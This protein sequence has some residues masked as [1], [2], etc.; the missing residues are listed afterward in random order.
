MYLFFDTETT[1]LPRDWS[2]PVTDLTN[3]PRLV[4]LAW[5]FYENEGRLVSSGNYIIRPNGFRIPKAASSIHGITTEKAHSHGIAL[6]TALLEF[7]EFMKASRY[8][9]A[10][11]ISFD[12]KIVAAEL[13]RTGMENLFE[14]KK[15][16]C[17]MMGTT[18]YCGIEGNYGE[19]WP[20]L[21]ELHDKVFKETF[22]D[23]HDAAMDIKITAK[24]FWELRKRRVLFY[25]I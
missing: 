1:G 21:T 9:I 16:I 17:T 8:L 15:K 7:V 24:C 2:A 6:E 12:E 22:E 10:H 19:K 14:S 13:I 3:W 18:Q 20:K 23:A 5:L 4:Q 25:N 11:N